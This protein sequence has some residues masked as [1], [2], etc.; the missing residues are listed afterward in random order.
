MYLASSPGETTSVVSNS[1]ARSR[2]GVLSMISFVGAAAAP[3]VVVAALTSTAWA[4]TGFV[5]IPVVFL[6]I[7]AV[8][9]LFAFGYTAMARQVTN[10]GAL[11]SYITHGLGRPLGVGAAGIALLAYNG[12]QVGLY[13]VFGAVT[14]DTIHT[15]T[16]LALPWWAYALLAWAVVAV[17]GILRVDLNGRILTL[18][19]AAECAIVLLGDVA[20]LLHPAGGHISLTALSP[21][22]LATAA[23]GAPIVVVATAFVG[24]E[25][26]TVYAEEARDP[27]RSVAVATFTALG[28]IAVL[29]ALTS[30]ALTVAIGPAQIVAA[31]AQ[32]GP[33][34]LFNTISG[35]LGATVGTIAQLLLLTSIFAGLIAFHNT[36]ARYTFALGRERVLPAVMGRTGQRSGSPLA[37]S[38]TQTAVG[39]VVI[40]LYA[41]LGL[42]PMVDLFFTLGTGGGL[43]VLLLLAG[44][45]VSVVVFLARQRGS[46][47]SLW[48]RVIAPVLA[49][50][51]LIVGAVL[52]L[53]KIDT[54]LGMPPG[55]PLT[56]LIPLL[57]LAVLAAGVG[58]AVV[59]RASNPTAY[60]LVGRGAEAELGA[61]AATPTTAR[62]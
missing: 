41:V 11:Y 18:L 25:A 48:H 16:G 31:A 30:W 51:G 42:D 15:L 21:S 13:G 58:W 44:T 50:V 27:R 19:L 47:L 46:G 23:V 12:L 57:Y 40:L 59:L 49:T 26:P 6:L 33:A 29:Y 4:V 3:L 10:A 53:L 28:A 52:A 14:G 34:L 24:F 1:L 62:V 56:W 20:M 38:L 60:A 43:G 2:I 45:S 22:N 39:L 54:L 36:V 7:G 37:G 55:S 8:L 5:G 9:M 32:Q 17:C 35:Q 61:E